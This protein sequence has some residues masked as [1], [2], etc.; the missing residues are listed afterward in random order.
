MWLQPQK[1]DKSLKQF[2]FLIQNKTKE[3]VPSISSCKNHKSG[4]LLTKLMTDNTEPKSH[5]ETDCAR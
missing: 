4:K 1:K 3:V 5:G 2:R